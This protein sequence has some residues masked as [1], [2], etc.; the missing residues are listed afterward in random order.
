MKFGIK[1]QTKNNKLYIGGI[2]AEKLVKD[3]G[4]PLYVYDEALIRQRFSQ[5]KKC[6][7][8]KKVDVH[9]ACKA[10]TNIRIMEILQEEG[11]FIDAVSPG[12]VHLALEA[13]FPSSKI[14]FTGSNSTD[15]DMLFCIKNK[16]LVNIDSLSQLERYGRLN[17]I[18]KV[19]VRINPDVGAG[20]HGHCITGGQESKFGIYYNK[21]KEIKKIAE[22]Y[23]LTIIGLHS[24]I[25][26]GILNVDDFL[27][28]VRVTLEAAANFSGLEFVDFGGGIGVPYRPDEKAVDLAS[29]GREVSSLFSSF[30]RK[31]G[32]NLTLKIEP[33]RFLVC[34]AGYLLCTVNTLKETPAHRFA[35]VDT[36][37]NHLVRPTMYGSYHQIVNASNVNGKKEKIAIAGN[38]CESGDVF[39]RDEDGIVDRE[40]SKI[41]EGDVIAILNAGA[42]GFSMSSN[43]NSRL[44]PAEV[45]VDNGKARIIRERQSFEDLIRG[46]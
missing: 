2:S 9:F 46:Q 44:L 27:L 24:H 13:G 19:Y 4:S 12:E 41:S 8:W 17:P 28:A 25:G 20:H 21:I 43:Y 42:Y 18:S 36:G 11:A 33:G 37:F 14:L 6:F 35:G 40:I 26:S 30:C 34:E 1:M 38:L 45:L 39:T 29:F 3:F 5:L 23:K 10:N 32:K 7:S 15:E 31:Y 16:V 22:K